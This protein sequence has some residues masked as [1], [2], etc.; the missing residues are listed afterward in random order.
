MVWFELRDN[1]LKFRIAG[2]EYE[3]RLDSRDKRDKIEFSVYF[4]KR[5]KDDLELLFWLLRQIPE[6]AHSVSSALKSV[7]QTC[8]QCIEQQSAKCL[9]VEERTK[10]LEE[11]I[12]LLK[13]KLQ[14]CETR[15]QKYLKRYRKCRQ[16]VDRLSQEVARLKIEYLAEVTVKLRT[17]AFL[18]SVEVTVTCPRIVAEV[19]KIVV[20]KLRPSKTQL[21]EILAG[22]QRKELIRRYEIS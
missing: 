18:K 10:K 1:I 7:L 15:Q 4:S 16:I 9:E 5:R 11:H 22:L 8:R 6:N 17:E 3:I 13:S 2:I 19:L 20:D 21:E 14:E 12:Q